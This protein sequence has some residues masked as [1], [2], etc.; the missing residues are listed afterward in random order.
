MSDQPNTI[1]GILNDTIDWLNLSDKAFDLICEARGIPNPASGDEVQ[2]GL[3]RLS[4]W[5]AS[6]PGIDARAFQA[7]TS[8]VDYPRLPRA[9]QFM[10]CTECTP[11]TG[12]TMQ[13][14]CILYEP[15]TKTR[16]AA[17]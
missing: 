4:Q 6:N 16:T 13:P 15:R 7:I 9:R 17:R 2:E 11:E 8:A 12:H 10:D 3:R 5:F 1:V 14:G